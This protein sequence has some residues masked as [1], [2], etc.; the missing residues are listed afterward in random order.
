MEK[1]KYINLNKESATC[2]LANVL[3]A[4]CSTSHPES[5]L[6]RA[7]QNILMASFADPPNES[8]RYA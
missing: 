3:Y 7:N 1:P 5:P 2:W 4:Y 6:C 8:L